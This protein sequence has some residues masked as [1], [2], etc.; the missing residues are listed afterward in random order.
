[1][2]VGNVHENTLHQSEKASL[3]KLSILAKFKKGLFMIV[4]SENVITHI[5]KVLLV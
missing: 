1:M 2:S 4:L 5:V 3:A